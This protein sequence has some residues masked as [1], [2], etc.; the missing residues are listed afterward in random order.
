MQEGKDVDSGTKS[1]VNVARIPE[2]C[3]PVKTQRPIQSS[4]HCICVHYTPNKRTLRNMLKRRENES[5]PTVT[6]VGSLR[7]EANVM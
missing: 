2:V 5:E 4:F 7:S 6:E 1:H 3:T